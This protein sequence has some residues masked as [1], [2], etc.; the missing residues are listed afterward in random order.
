M[1]SQLELDIN[2]KHLVIGTLLR[3]MAS[4]LSFYYFYPEPSNFTQNVLG[5][6][7]GTTMLL[8]LLTFQKN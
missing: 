5:L 2:K 1:R 7:C 3:G 8:G 6:A 4:G